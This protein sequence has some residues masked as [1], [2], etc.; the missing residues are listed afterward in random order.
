MFGISTAAVIRAVLAS[1]IPFPVITRPFHSR[2]LSLQ[3]S[4]RLLTVRATGFEL[5]AYPAVRDSIFALS[6]SASASEMYTF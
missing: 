5:L 4:V 6:K 3:T 2:A 1:T